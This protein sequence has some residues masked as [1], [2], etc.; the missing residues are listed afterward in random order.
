MP[1]NSKQLA[2]ARNLTPDNIRQLKAQ[3]MLAPEL[4]ALCVDDTWLNACVAAIQEAPDWLRRQ[5]EDGAQLPAFIAEHQR[6]QAGAVFL[7]QAAAAAA[8]E[9]WLRDADACIQLARR[10]AQRWS[11]IEGLTYDAPATPV[12]PLATLPDSL[13]AERVLHDVRAWAPIEDMVLLAARAGRSAEPASRAAP[14]VKTVVPVKTWGCTPAGTGPLTLILETVPDRQPGLWR[15][16]SAGL[17]VVDAAFLAATQDAWTWAVTSGGL[18]PHTSV[19]WRLLDVNGTRVPQVTGNSAGLAFAVA[20]HQAGV[21]WRRLRALHTA[22]SYLGS[23]TVEGTVAMPS[24]GVTPQTSRHVRYV[25]APTKQ[26]SDTP[27]RRTLEPIRLGLR[28]V[29]SRQP[30]CSEPR[31][32]ASLRNALVACCSLPCTGGPYVALPSGQLI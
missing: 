7:A 17:T 29:R 16:P 20:L 19:R 14:A 24:P 9:A 6:S 21:S 23:V 30:N 31:W 13:Q 3:E 11:A 25:I 5:A 28:A 10:A 4:D 27:T 26:L 8:A 12:R 22:T 32:S 18:N 15:A 1:M 2:A